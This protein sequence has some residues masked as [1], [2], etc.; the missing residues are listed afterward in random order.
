MAAFLARFTLRRNSTFGTDDPEY[1][2]RMSVVGQGIQLQEV[3]A[4]TRPARVAWLLPPNVTAAELNRIIQWATEHVGLWRSAMWQ[5]EASGQLHLLGRHLLRKY[6]P[7]VVYGIRVNVDEGYVRDLLNPFEIVTEDDLTDR[8]SPGVHVIDVGVM[9]AAEPDK[10][11]VDRRVFAGDPLRARWAS[12]Q[13]GILSDEVADRLAANG[14]PVNTIQV[15]LDDTNQ[16]Y[17]VS[18]L[19]L[20][21]WMP[22]PPISP[23]LIQQRHLALMS[24][25]RDNWYG[26]PAVIVVGDSVRDF[27][28]YWTLRAIRSGVYWAPKEGLTNWPSLVEQFRMLITYRIPR[29]HQSTSLISLSVPE[30]ALAQ[31]S[32]D[33]GPSPAHA[34][35]APPSVIPIAEIDRL[36]PGLMVE[37]VMYSMRTDSLFFFH[38]VSGAQLPTASAG[39]I[40]LAEPAKLHLFHEVAV[41]AHQVPARSQY[42]RRLEPEIGRGSRA[43]REGWSYSPIRPFIFG[44]DTWE[45]AQ[46]G[47]RLRL[48]D[49]V[50]ECLTVIP[51][52]L[53]PQLSAAGQYLVRASSLFEG[54]REAAAFLTRPPVARLLDAYK[55]NKKNPS[56]DQ[57]PGEILSDRRYLDFHDLAAATGLDGD[58]LRSLLEELVGRHVLR[59]GFAFKCPVCRWADFYRLG[60]FDDEFECRQCSRKTRWQ[61]EDARHPEAPEVF[62]GLDEIVYRVAETDGH[63]VLRAFTWV[64]EGVSSFM[65][66][67]G[68]NVDWPNQAD[69]WEFDAVLLL[70]GRVAL[71][72]VKNA[73]TVGQRQ[74][75]RYQSMAERLSADQVFIVSTKGWD[76]ATTTRI[77]QLRETLRSRYIEVRIANLE[78]EHLV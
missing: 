65:A 11:S 10:R 64:S 33:V 75:N 78:L 29:E 30:P 76:A 40:A 9:E 42:N 56:N 44:Y 52:E 15:N 61:L 31:V 46:V 53:T 58:P 73:A 32:D 77:E 19:V 63:A 55:R 8:D 62:Y 51:S 66:A 70:D 13:L 54:L 3:Q 48:H 43:S 49:A 41:L 47:A 25:T 60:T 6:D 22:A 39:R 5:V 23:C 26:T 69:P 38:N 1:P 21:P 16:F 2:V 45:T 74:L 57:V 34:R 72:E 59:R 27:C 67:P 36:L 17:G 14:T 20:D 7:D 4:A 50:D 28:L 24:K 71:V 35:V 18:S 68:V 37:Q 12:S